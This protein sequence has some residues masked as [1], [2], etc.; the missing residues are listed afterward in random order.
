MV[1]QQ[2][3]TLRNGATEAERKLWQ[4]LRHL[5]AESFHFRRQVPIGSAIAD[6]ACHRAKLVIEI[7]GGQ[8]G[9]PDRLLGDERRT[10]ML[11]RHG[12][13]VIRF[14]NVEVFQN[15]DGVIAGIRR[16]IGLESF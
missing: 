9:V 5:K 15:I 1:N 4:Q 8:H 3:R 6:F 10:E 14:W 16:E 2:A 11:A 7:D 12:F 13:R